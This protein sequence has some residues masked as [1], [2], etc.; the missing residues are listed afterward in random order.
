[1]CEVLTPISRRFAEPEPEAK[2]RRTS[3]PGEQRCGNLRVAGRKIGEHPKSRNKFLSPDRVGVSHMTSLPTTVLALSMYLISPGLRPICHAAT[4]QFQRI[5]SAIRPG[6]YATAAQLECN[7]SASRL[8]RRAQLGAFAA[9]RRR[10]A[11]GSSGVRRLAAFCSARPGHP[12]DPP[13]RRPRRRVISLARLTFALRWSARRQA[14]RAIARWASPQ[15]ATHRCSNLTGGRQE[16]VT[17]P[18]NRTRPR[19]DLA[20]RDATP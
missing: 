17:R 2:G 12:A 3:I 1:M 13:G 10:S 15:R 18:C 14:H 16:G 20:E 9:G 19:R 5:I 8:I 7:H 11:C 6:G 4:M